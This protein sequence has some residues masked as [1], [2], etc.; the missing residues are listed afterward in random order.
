MFN[1]GL[2]YVKIT[3]LKSYIL[4]NK[5]G[6]TCLR[7]NFVWE[8]F[9]EILF[10]PFPKPGW[11]YHWLPIWLHR[12]FLHYWLRAVGRVSMLAGRGGGWVK[13]STIMVGRRRK[14]FLK[15]QMIQNINDPKSHI[16]NSFFENIIFAHT[17]QWTSSQFFCSRFSSRKSQS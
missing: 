4:Y 11:L 2:H 1:L 9:W 5:V 13:M 12:W 6:F 8:F 15:N 3:I 10:V 7:T 17:F 14:F 16:C